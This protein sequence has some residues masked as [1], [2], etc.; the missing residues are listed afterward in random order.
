[1]ELNMDTHA[2]PHAATISSVQARLD[3][4]AAQIAS[5]TERQQRS[6]ELFAE[7]TPILRAMMAT[8]TT[9]LDALEKRGYF[10]FGRELVSVGERIVEGFSPADVHQLGDAVVSILE[11]VRA[12][13][14]P[15]VLEIAG[16]A[17]QAIQHVGETEPLGLLGMVRATRDDDVQKGM[18]VLMDLMKHVG[19]AAALIADKRSS[20]PMAQ[21]RAKLSAITGAK[22]KPKTPLGIESERAPVAAPACATPKPAAK[23]PVVVAATLD[24]VGFAADGSLVD[25]AAWTRELAT[26]IAAA[27][28]VTLGVEQWKVIDFARA[29]F[30]QSGASPNIRR[31]T[32]STGLTTKDLYSLFPRAPARSAARIAGLPKP[33]GC[34]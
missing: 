7:M 30:A 2:I 20:S 15:E 3:E 17:S 26:K 6:E 21:K 8:A 25:P 33:A 34:I 18:A 1:M 12:M 28:G 24:G 14:Q 16:E 4:I 5:L 9:R 11:T 31:I 27:E 29:D 23:G 32:Q 10:A 13:T 19:R 22:K